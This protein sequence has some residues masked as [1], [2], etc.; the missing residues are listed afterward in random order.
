[1]Q[2]HNLQPQTLQLVKEAQHFTQSKSQLMQLLND[3]DTSISQYTQSN[4]GADGTFI[5]ELHLLKEA[6]H[7]LAQGNLQ[8]TIV[9][10]KK[11][12]KS[13]LLNALLGEEK[14]P[15]GLDACTAVPIRIRYGL[16]KKVAIHFHDETP[17]QYVDT[18]VFFEEYTLP[19]GGG[20]DPFPNIKH[21][22]MEAPIELLKSGIELVDTPGL[23][24]CEDLDGRT[25][26]QTKDSPIV[27]YT[28]SALQQY[29]AS[30][31]EAI[32]T[33]RKQ[34]PEREMFLVINHWD[35][36]TQKLIDPESSYERAQAEQAIRKTF[37][38]IYNHSKSQTKAHEH[39][40]FEVS[41]LSALRSRLRKE[42]ITDVGFNKLEN[43]ITAFLKSSYGKIYI[44]STLASTDKI[45]YSIAR[46]TRRLTSLLEKDLKDLE[47]SY[48]KMQV[49][50]LDMEEIR[51]EFI[52]VLESAKALLSKNI[53]KRLC[54]RIETMKESFE[55]D[56]AEYIGDIEFVDLLR[57]RGRAELEEKLSAA[58][59]KYLIQQ[60]TICLT[61]IQ[62]DK[63]SIYRQ[64]SQHA[65]VY[66]KRY[67]KK[68][69]E[70]DQVLNIETQTKQSI[71]QHALVWD[72]IDKNLE[73][74]KHLEDWDGIKHINTDDFGATYFISQLITPLITALLLRLAFGALLGPILATATI[75][76]GGGAALRSFGTKQITQRVVTKAKEIVIDELPVISSLIHAKLDKSLNE[77]FQTLQHTFADYLSTDISGRNMNIQKIINAKKDRSLD[78]SE[79]KRLRKLHKEVSSANAFVHQICK[80][81]LG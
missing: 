46:E 70:I 30:E 29:T 45:V 74:N 64:I 19:P 54:E 60:F 25:F 63:E 17:I 21:A 22:V 20:I 13:T 51:Q 58:L 80:E 15:M 78:G 11:R 38:E 23:N 44:R 69:V 55:N 32:D 27:L 42:D 61:T 1:M 39:R 12:G 40:V 59:S 43:A 71:F 53:E 31:R 81:Y 68:V 9:G 52:Q 2:N 75:L 7:F 62:E 47:D 48:Q 76:I 41:A 49:H 18:K 56:F 73:N 77:N 5:S 35:V 33:L 14:F 79:L 72:I 10:E 57:G 65:E 50:I 34:Q 36:I 67:E 6:I 3:I 26:S 28:L 66:Q 24:D 4:Q 37:N 8:I 16:R